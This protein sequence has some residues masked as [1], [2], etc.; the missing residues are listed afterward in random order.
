MNNRPNYRTIWT[1]ITIILIFAVPG[2]AGPNSSSTPSSVATA[3][4]TP[5]VMET[6]IS[7]IPPEPTATPTTA[8]APTPKPTSQPDVLYQDDFSDPNSGWKIQEFDNYFIGYHE[9]S[10]Y[11]VEVHNPNDKALVQVPGKKTFDD[12]TV[13]TKVLTSVNNTAKSGDFRYGLFFRRSGNQYY[14]F[15]IS[16]ST[17]KWYVLKSSPGALTVLKEGVDESIQGLTAEDSLRVDAKGSTFFFHINDKLID[18]VNDTDYAKGETG[19]YVETIDSPRVHAHFDQITIRDVEAPQWTCSVLVSSANLR[20]GPSTAYLPV[21]ILSQ[22]DMFEALGRNL[23]GQ[24]IQARVIGS[25][26]QGWVYSYP[27]FVSCNVETADLPIVEQ[28]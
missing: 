16:P 13:E 1:F 14:A 9:P 18:F 17:K 24:W 28:P 6:A 11:H 4:P 22:G 19:F 12:F 2:C 5:V 15:A 10:Y 26:Q 27:K 23:D 21:S 7:T 25:D 20:S 8:A 3:P